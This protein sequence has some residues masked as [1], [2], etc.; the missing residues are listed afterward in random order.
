[1][2]KTW[3][4]SGK[5]YKCFQNSNRELLERGLQQKQMLKGEHNKINL[6]EICANTRNCFEIV[7]DPTANKVSS[8]Y[9]YVYI[10]IYIY[11]LPDMAP[12]FLK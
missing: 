12:S 4:Q 11:N 5:T 6:K 8:I 10:Y 1:M 7:N 9:I 2:G 3:G